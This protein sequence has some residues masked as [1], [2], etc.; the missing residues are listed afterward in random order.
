MTMHLSSIR[1]H[2]EQA[3]V[4]VSC[5]A[6]LLSSATGCSFVLVKPLPAA[7]P[8]AEGPGALPASA[9]RCTE[10]RAAPVTDTVV[11]GVL[12]AT[13]AVA[14]AASSKSCDPGSLGCI[15]KG[16]AL[17]IGVTTGL[18]SL[19]FLGSATYG[20]SKVSQCRAARRPA[21][22]RPCDVGDPACVRVSWAPPM[23]GPVVEAAPGGG[24]E[25]RIG[26]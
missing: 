13:A 3:L 23:S 20:Y 24:A 17:G 1:T 6:A 11:G 16:M 4:L 26:P 25:A 14:L 8:A 5:C 22:F 10:S 21:A 15:G 19:A 12:L 9:P 2:T 7:P 18:P